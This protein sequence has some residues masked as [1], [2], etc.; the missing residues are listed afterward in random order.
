M[1]SRNEFVLSQNSG[2]YSKTATHT[3]RCLGAKRLIRI[4]II[5]IMTFLIHSLQRKILNLHMHCLLVYLV[6]LDTCIYFYLVFGTRLT[7]YSYR[8]YLFKQL[9]TPG[10]LRHTV[11]SEY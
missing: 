6:H 1:I 2:V 4:I 10:M 7:V 11:Y 3:I 9:K 8:H 5:I